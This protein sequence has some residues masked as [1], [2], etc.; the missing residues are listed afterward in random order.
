MAHMAK[1]LNL[2]SQDSNPT[3]DAYGRPRRLTWKS[4]G[5]RSPRMLGHA[6]IFQGG[7]GLRSLRIWR[8]K[9]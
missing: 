6:G 9:P 3:T 5:K 1:A 7:F 4:S 2:I 8:A